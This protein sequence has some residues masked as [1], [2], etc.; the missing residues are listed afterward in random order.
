M[1]IFTQFGTTKDIEVSGIWV[2]FNPNDDGSIPGF[3]IARAGGSN[4]L[5]ERT[6]SR[7]TK[8][9]QVAIRNGTLGL[10]QAKKINID[11]FIEAVLRDWRNVYNRYGSPIPFSAHN[12]RELFNE[13][14]DLYSALLDMATNV[15]TFQHEDKEDT[16]KN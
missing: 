12:A 2:E 5:Y 14:P 16:V 8:P 3:L 6:L 4:T 10:D 11:V 7:K 1:S 15:S 9:F 13:L